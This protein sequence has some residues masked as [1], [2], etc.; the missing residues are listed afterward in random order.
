VID[1]SDVAAQEALAQVV[2]QTGFSQADI[3]AWTLVASMADAEA[4]L[5]DYELAGQRPGA[6][7]FERMLAAVTLLGEICNALIPL[8]G[9]AGGIKNLL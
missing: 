4:L 6:D 8:T 3:V 2:G 1:F 7:W 5:R 9:L